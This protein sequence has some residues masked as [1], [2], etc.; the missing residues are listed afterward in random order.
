MKAPVHQSIALELILHTCYSRVSVFSFSGKS[1]RKI[2][3]TIVLLSRTLTRKLIVRLFFAA[4]F[5]NYLEIVRD[6]V[7]DS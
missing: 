4:I 1:G 7:R 5:K 2:K 3:L 6:F